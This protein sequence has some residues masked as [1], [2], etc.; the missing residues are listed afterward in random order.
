MKCEKVQ[1]NLSAYVDSEIGSRLRQRM[2]KHLAG[3]PMCAAERDRIEKVAAAASSSVRLFLSDKEAPR[4][5]RAQ[6]MDRLEQSPARRVVVMPARRLAAAALT[7]LVAA[8]FLGILF[9]SGFSL[10]RQ[11]LRNEIAECRAA[12][13]VARTNRDKAR[14][15][16]AAAQATLGVVDE[17]LR[18]AQRRID[19]S[20]RLAAQVPGGERYVWRP[21]LSSLQ[22]PGARALLE[23]GVF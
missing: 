7:G 3:C 15:E 4:D 2:E 22:M 12:L 19:E 1:K 6:V 20:E 9:Q 17:E 5:L 21:V 16:L 10:Q 8:F 11:A 18:L 23:N 13:R 14:A